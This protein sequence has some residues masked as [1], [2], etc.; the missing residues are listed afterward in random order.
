[1]AV[2]VKDYDT[3]STPAPTSGWRVI[4]KTGSG[5]S[6]T[7]TLTTAGGTAIGYWWYTQNSGY[8]PWSTVR[9]GITQFF[10]DYYLNSSWAASVRMPLTNNT[11]SDDALNIYNSGIDNHTGSVHYW[12]SNAAGSTGFIVTGNYA[13]AYTNMNANWGYL[14]RPVVQIRAGI[15]T[16]ESKVSYLGQSCWTLK[17]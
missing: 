16:D 4:A 14:L 10:N 7:V 13:A 1:M 2:S 15:K 17:Q 11:I 8:L 3:S 6:G 12:C 9:A 5:S